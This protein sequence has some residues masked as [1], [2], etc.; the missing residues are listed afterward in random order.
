MAMTKALTKMFLAEL[1]LVVTV[2]A[3]FRFLGGFS[4][5]KSAVLTFAAWIVYAVVYRE[6]L[7]MKKARHAERS[8]PALVTR[9]RIEKVF[10]PFRVSIQPNWYELLSDF[11]LIRSVEDW[12]RAFAEAGKLQALED[13]I[14]RR[15]LNFT[16]I[17]PPSDNGLEPGLVFWDDRKLFLSHDAELREVLIRDNSVPSVKEILGKHPIFDHPR[18]PSPALFFRSFGG[19]QIG[20]EVG[21]EWWEELCKCGQAG[22]LAETEADADY[23]LFGKTRLVIATLP[24]SEFDAYYKNLG[25]NQ[26]NRQAEV[27]DKQLEANGWTRKIEGDSDIPDPWSHLQH[28]YFKVSHRRV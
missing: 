14:F 7:A 18:S 10:S 5:R 1:V 19:Y 15:G 20:L 6:A 28:K 24:Y 2:Y 11:K 17:R 23:L 3:S 16:V 8:I 25:D 4:F 27:L 9:R 21:P 13:H 22:E 26:M 12:H